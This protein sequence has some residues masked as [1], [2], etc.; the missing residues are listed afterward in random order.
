MKHFSVLLYSM[1][2][3]SSVI[4]SIPIFAE[5]E[6]VKNVSE[7]PPAIVETPKEAPE[8]AK[9]VSKEVAK[10]SIKESK[11]AANPIGF[12]GDYRFRY[13]SDALEPS[14]QRPMTRLQLKFG[15]QAMVHEDL[16]F[17]GRLMTG[18]SAESGNQTLGGQKTATSSRRTTGIDQAFLQGNLC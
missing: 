1:I 4:Y 2:L 5:E 15:F 10:E 17:Q 12:F 18:T 7:A 13:M 14:Q 11:P 6:K 16:L 8:T 3:F 9:E